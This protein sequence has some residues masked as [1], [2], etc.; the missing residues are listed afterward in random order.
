MARPARA[1][2][3]GGDVAVLT[4][5]LAENIK[6]LIQLE[7][8]VQQGQDQADFLRQLNSG[9]ENSI[10]ILQSLPV[11]DEKILGDLR[12]FQ[13]AIRS[14]TSVYGMIPKSQE[15]VMQTLH[16]QTIAESLRMVNT[17]KD[18]SDTQERNSIMIAAQSRE[19][20][21]LY[22][23]K[24]GDKSANELVNMARDLTDEITKLGRAACIHLIAAT[25]K[26]TTK[27]IDTDVQENIGGRICFRVGTLQG[28][29][30]VLGNKKAFELPDIKGRAIWAR[31][32]DFTEVQTPFVSEKFIGQ[33]ISAIKGDFESGKRKCLQPLLVPAVAGVEVESTLK[34]LGK[35]ETAE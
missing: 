32:N 9:I 3:F 21:V 8:M 28:S 26:V 29:N 14:V 35:E 20:S 34:G 17:F 13:G 10:G 11:K 12:E 23:K 7:Q 22:K 5:I 16:D 31:G 4:Q 1:D 25:Q 27:T 15:S 19:A 2:L 33:Q 24:A 30:V 6:Q 18:Y